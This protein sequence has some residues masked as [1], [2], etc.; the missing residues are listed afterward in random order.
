M[1]K[2]A[3]QNS[4]NKMSKTNLFW[5]KRRLYS[6]SQW[7]QNSASTFSKWYWRMRW[8]VAN[9]KRQTLSR[10]MVVVGDLSTMRDCQGQLWVRINS[11]HKSR[12]WN[13]K[14]SQSFMM[15]PDKA[16]W[17]TPNQKFSLEPLS[18][19]SMNTSCRINF[20]LTWRIIVRSWWSIR[21]KPASQVCS[22]TARAC[23]PCRILAG[24][25][26]QSTLWK[27]WEMP[28]SIPVVRQASSKNWNGYRKVRLKWSILS[29]AN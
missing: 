13:E 19:A 2:G 26:P 16:L 22:S 9:L 25:G 24:R 5:H 20:G 28:S 8:I 29:I 10:A 23:H 1:I 4:L 27:R 17:T 21:V 14:R 6:S 7:L 12:I 18:S 15:Q 11:E 3:I